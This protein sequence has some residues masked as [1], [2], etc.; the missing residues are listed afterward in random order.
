MG[1]I[2]FFGVSIVNKFASLALVCVLGTIVCMFTGIVYNFNGNDLANICV[3]GTRLVNKVSNCTKDPVYGEELWNTFCTRL[4]NA[5]DTWQNQ[6]TPFDY[7]CD[8]YFEEENE[9]EFWG[10]MPL[11]L[12]NYS[13]DKDKN[14]NCQL[15]IFFKIWKCSSTLSKL[16][17]VLSA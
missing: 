8:E 9:M 12:A 10:T 5:T 4:E 6:T 17:I 3:V 13:C 2:V 15:K 11:N 7:E 14:S 16:S 1:T